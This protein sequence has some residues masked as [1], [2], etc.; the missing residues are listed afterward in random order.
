MTH[1]TIDDDDEEEEDGMCILCMMMIT[2]AEERILSCGGKVNALW[3]NDT[4][5]EWTKEFLY[6]GTYFFK[7]VGFEAGLSKEQ[8]TSNGGTKVGGGA[9]AE[10]LKRGTADRRDRLRW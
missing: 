1:S 4:I 2:E 5:D 10:C 3:A 7:E 6:Y 8:R 9:S